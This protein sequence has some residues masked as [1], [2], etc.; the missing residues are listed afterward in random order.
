M[1]LDNHRRLQILACDLIEDAG[2]ALKLPR[3]AIAT[4]QMLLHRVTQCP[5][6]QLNNNHLDIISMTA[7]FTATKIEE[8][9][10]KARHVIEV[11]TYVISNRLNKNIVLTPKEN[12]KIREELITSERKLLKELGF[13]LLSSCPHK[14][15]IIYYP[16]L[17][18]LL[19]EHVTIW[20]KH[21]RERLLQLAWNYCN[22]SLRLDLCLKFSQE[23]VAFACIQ[24]A[25]EDLNMPLPKTTNGRE[26]YL[27]FVDDREKVESTIK[28]IRSL[29]EL[30][31]I[32]LREHKKSLLIDSLSG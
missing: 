2:L 17:L 20:R 4:A 27:L 18:D 24:M 11:F 32:D 8:E 19:D 16:Y 26:W 13:N 10:R 22:D 5:D 6:F 3:V 21:H 23:I 31:M 9:P 30:D 29:Y 7:L 25:C 14:L 1:D 12:E 15:I 28:L